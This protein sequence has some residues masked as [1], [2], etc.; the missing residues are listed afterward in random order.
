MHL[1]I[2]CTRLLRWLLRV[3]GWS[4]LS[5][6]VVILLA[7]ILNYPLAKYNISVSACRICL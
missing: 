2:S 4:A 6:V 1:A 7:Y 5:G 3:L